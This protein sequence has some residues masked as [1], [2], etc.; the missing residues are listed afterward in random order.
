VP[1]FNVPAHSDS[2]VTT[3]RRERESRDGGLEGE[4]VEG[5]PSRDVGQYFLAVFVNGEEEVTPRGEA[6]S[7]DILP[8]RKREG[9]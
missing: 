6:E 9:M 1:Y 3:G 5:N 7:R 4:V 8:V 2:E